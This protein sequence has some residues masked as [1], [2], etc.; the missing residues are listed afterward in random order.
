MGML[1]AL[2]LLW[3]RFSR[4]L[5]PWILHAGTL[6]LHGKN[7][8]A[9]FITDDGVDCWPDRHWYYLPC[10]SCWVCAGCCNDVDEHPST[11]CAWSLR[12]RAGAPIALVCACSSL[13]QMRR[14]RKA[15]EMMRILTGV[16][17][18]Y[19][20]H[21]QEITLTHISECL[22]ALEASN[23]AQARANQYPQRTS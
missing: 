8:A 21:P 1:V 16:S 17:L 10:C 20:I 7:P 11:I 19:Y 6:L 13:N 12:K 22:S 3:Y 9:L 5:P 23:T 4:K 15:R 14:A 2:L 18:P